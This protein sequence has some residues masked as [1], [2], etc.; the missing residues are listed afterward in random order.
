MK[1][2]RWKASKE[3]NLAEKGGTPA[4]ERLESFSESFVIVAIKVY[5]LEKFH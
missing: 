4:L 2:R 3:E 1:K 5:R